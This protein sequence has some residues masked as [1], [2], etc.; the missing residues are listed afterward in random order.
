MGLPYGLEIIL[1]QLS[2]KGTVSSWQI[3][4]EKSGAICAKIRFEC[5]QGD[6][7]SVDNIPNVSYKKKSKRQ[8]DRD[9]KRAMDYN[10]NGVTTRSKSRKHLDSELPRFNEDSLNSETT[11]PDLDVNICDTPEKVSASSPLNHESPLLLDTTDPNPS[12]PVLEVNNN[13]SEQLMDDINDQVTNS[14]MY[15]ET[16]TKCDYGSTNERCD[17]CDFSCGIIWRRCTHID[18]TRSY[19]ICNSCYHGGHYHSE[20][21][22]QLTMFELPIKLDHQHMCFSCG[23]TFKN[24]CSEVIICQICPNYCLC[25]NCFDKKK[26]KGHALHM[27]CI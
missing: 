20:H 7:S 10:K 6:H 19:N 9:Q 5:D 13:I 11:I 18:H 4:E 23:K 16:E 14:N 8:M 2:A 24:N 25:S 17:I 26:H 22:D 27:D 15:E 12:P 1:E 3:F 21:S